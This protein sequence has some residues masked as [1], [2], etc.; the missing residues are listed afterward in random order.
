M[1][2]DDIKLNGEDV[3]RIRALRDLSLD[4]LARR[5]GWNKSKQ[6][7]LERNVRPLSPADEVR[8]IRV[9]WG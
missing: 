5:C 4:E 9:L 8:L 7:L 1:K 6:H 2:D 3:A